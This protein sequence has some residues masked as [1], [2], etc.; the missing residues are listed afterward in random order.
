MLTVPPG[1]SQA[2]LSQ[3]LGL[4]RTTVYRLLAKLVE[5]GLIR[6]DAKRRS[7]ALGLQVFRAGAPVGSLNPDL[8]LAAAPELRMLRDLTGET[9]YLAVLEG[10]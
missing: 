9:T 10:K 8:V 3:K 5:R 4:P 1:L 2:A 7:Y 6:H